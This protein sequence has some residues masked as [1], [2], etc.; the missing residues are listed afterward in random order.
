MYWSGAGEAVADDGLPLAAPDRNHRVDRLEPGL[1]RLLDR[2]ALDDA[3]GVEFDRPVMVRPDPP[4][5]VARPAERVD[6]T[7]EQGLAHR[8][9]EHA[10]GAAHL[11]ALLDR[12]VIAH[13]DRAD[14]V[15]LEV[16]G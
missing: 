13:D 3:G 14:H 1:E 6:D 2:L 10:A 15:L 7:A 16:E 5:A 9:L 4:F 11:V 8:H 12:D